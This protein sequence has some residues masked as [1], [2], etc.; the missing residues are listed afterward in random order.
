MSDSIMDSLSSIL[1]GK[2]KPIYVGRGRRTLY[3]IYKMLNR[4]KY[5]PHQSAREISRRRRQIELGQ[6]GPVFSA[7]AH[8][9]KHLVCGSRWIRQ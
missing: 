8:V 6:I 9:M 2:R 5:V 1:F 4:S 7:G 3:T